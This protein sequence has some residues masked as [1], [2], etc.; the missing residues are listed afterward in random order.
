MADNSSGRGAIDMNEKKGQLTAVQRHHLYVEAAARSGIHQAILAALY[1]VQANPVLTDGEIGLGIAPAN[2]IP[3]EQLD[4]FPAQVQYAANT[5]RSLTN[6]LIHEGWQSTE[7]WYAEQGRYTDKFVQAIAAGYTAPLNDPTAALL[8]ASDAESLL[9]AYVDCWSADAQ[10]AGLSG[11]FAGLDA[12]LMAFLGLLPRCYFSLLHQRDALVEAVRLW[13]HLDTREA[14]IASL[15][16]EPS[17][18]SEI[19]AV[20]LIDMALRRFVASVASN[21]AGYPHQREALLRLTQLWQQ[22]DSREA[23]IAVLLQHASPTLNFNNLDAAL[24]AIVQRLPQNY[25]GNGDQRNA[26]VETFRLWHQQDS[27]SET[28]MALGIHPDL[29][30]TAAPSQ[31]AITS[32]AVQL[33]Q[34]LLDFFHRLPLLYTG[35]DVQRNAL[36]RLTQLWRSI[37]TPEQALQSLLN[38]LKQ[39]ATAVRDT[40]EAPPMPTPFP[41]PTRLDRWTTDTLQLHAAIIPNG[42]FTWAD[43]TNGGLRMPPNQSAIDAIIRLAQRVQQARDRIGRPFHVTSWYGAA[44]ATATSEISSSRYLLGDA[45]TFYCNGLTGAQLYWFLDPWWAGGLGRY[46]AFALLC[47]VD[48]RSDRARWVQ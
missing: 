41:L 29:F 47:Y 23:A 3:L 11:S 42:S 38:D 26:L 33:D 32:A 30:T 16:I 20:A 5:V 22:L 15:Q 12:A 48:A 46:K 19:E 31:A 18:Q 27:R 43:A 36:L 17:N 45:L 24:M 34:A 9:Q 6:R 14:A 21:Y 13:Q 44:D 35:K 7:L 28:L 40:P 25:E 37:S 2:Q 39:M 8:E 10:A 1:Q 4:T